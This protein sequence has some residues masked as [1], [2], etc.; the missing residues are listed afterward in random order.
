MKSAT[1][2]HTLR[3]AHVSTGK[4]S[5]QRRY[6]TPSGT[7]MP[8]PIAACDSPNIE[9]S[10]YRDGEADFAEIELRI[11]TRSCARFDVRMTPEVLREA[12]A[13]LLDAAHDIEAFP[14]AVLAKQAGE[15]IPTA[16]EK[17]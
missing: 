14:A 13:R 12:A 9:F 2:I 15:C 6:G 11:G 16:G 3:P 17:P 10:V 4:Y 5:N 7:G 8:R 1:F